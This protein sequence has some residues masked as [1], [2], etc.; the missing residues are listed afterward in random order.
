MMMMMMYTSSRERVLIAMIILQPYVSKSRSSAT[1][2]MLLVVSFYLIFTTL[3]VTVC[4]ALSLN[5]P[6]GD[7]ALTDPEA[8]DADPVWNRFTVYLNVRT[9]V[10]EIGLSHYACNFYIYLVT[11]RVFRHQL[12]RLLCRSPTAM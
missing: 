9:V 11:G 10:E 12:R 7:P 4:Y 2:F 1:T 3:P 5:F 8:R 6:Q